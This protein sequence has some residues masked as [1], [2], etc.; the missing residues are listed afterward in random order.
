MAVWELFKKIDR[1]H[2][3]ICYT[4]L[5]NTSHDETKSI[6]HSLEP[7]V[8]VVGR[9]WQRCPRCGGTNTKSFAEL[10]TE[11][12]DSALWGLERTVKKHPRN[13][14]DSRDHP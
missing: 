2:W 11:G 1:K 4:C 7:K 10:K 6:F 13:L 12:Q 5:G 14:F 3:F 9:L 8:D